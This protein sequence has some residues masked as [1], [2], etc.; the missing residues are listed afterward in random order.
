LGITMIYVT[1]DQAEALALSDRIAVMRQGAIEQLDTPRRIH[2]SPKT[3]FTAS[4]M[5]YENIFDI[6]GTT[7]TG[8]KAKVTAPEGTPSGAAKLAWRPSG[9]IIG[10]GPYQ[11]IVRG[12][13]Y[14]GEQTE[15]L[16]DG[17]LGPV[18]AEVPTTGDPYRAGQKVSFDMPLANAAVIGGAP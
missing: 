14:L 9:V 13:A 5:G 6:D 1:H 3:A 16:L 2:G 15:Y 8:N 7:M 11:G 4:F 12:V 10:T 18:K 17:P